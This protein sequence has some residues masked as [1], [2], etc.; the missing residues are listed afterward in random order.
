[1]EMANYI[2][3][4]LRSRIFVMMSWGFNTPVAIENGLRFNVQGFIH[5][6][7]V[8]VIYIAGKDLFEVRLLN[9][10]GS[11]KEQTSDVYLDCLVDVIDGLVE[12]CPNYEDRVE[13][14]Y[15]M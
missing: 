9:L 3:R 14:E 13:Q 12:R 11:I 1:M 7:K 2:L 4:I 10:D 6:G 8:E 5:T 15:G